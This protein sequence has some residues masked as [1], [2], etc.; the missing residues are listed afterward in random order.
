MGVND[1][2][3]TANEKAEEERKAALHLNGP[4][5]GGPE[6][7]QDNIDDL[8]AMDQDSIDALFD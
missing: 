5:I 4:A 8:L 6:V 7:E 1:A 3:A 2:E